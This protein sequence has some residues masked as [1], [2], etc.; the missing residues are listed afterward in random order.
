MKG[1]KRLYQDE[2]ADEGTV[3]NEMSS[4][5]HS[6]ALFDKLKSQ[7]AILALRTSALQAKLESHVLLCDLDAKDRIASVKDLIEV[8]VNKEYKHLKETATNYLKIM[9]EKGTGQLSDMESLHKRLL[10]FASTAEK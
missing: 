9:T 3:L 5:A 6:L 10:N 8:K 4:N 2:A 7:I 1:Q